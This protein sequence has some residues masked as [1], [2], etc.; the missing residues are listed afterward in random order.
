MIAGSTLIHSAIRALRMDTGYDAAHVIDLGLQFPESAEYT[1]DHKTALIR[2]LRTRLAA[3]PGVLDVTTARAP[4]D[5]EFRSAAVSLNAE[6]P[7]PQNMKAY[8]FYTWIQP[9]YFQTLGITMLL[10]H[11]FTA[12]AGQAEP[13]IVVSESAA[14]KLWPGQ[15]PVGRTLRH[16]YRRFLS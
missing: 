10:G 4:D 2:D 3:M 6:K 13:S 11:G 14:N 1:A 12:Q 15:N 5:G 8:L 16:G 9:N 7:S